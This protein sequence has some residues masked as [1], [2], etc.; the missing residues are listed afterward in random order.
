MRMSHGLEGC[1]YSRAFPSLVVYSIEVLATFFV[2]VTEL[3]VQNLGLVQKLVMEAKDHIADFECGFRGRLCR[4][5]PGYRIC[6]EV[7]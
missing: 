2:L 6:V 5:H 7:R 3:Y 1:E 4:S